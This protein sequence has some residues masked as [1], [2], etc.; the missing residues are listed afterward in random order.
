M[1]VVMFVIH[2]IHVLDLLTFVTDTHVTKDLPLK[3]ASTSYGMTAL[4]HSRSSL[5]VAARR[6]L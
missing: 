4:S 2:L 5:A 3:L 6:D 1:K